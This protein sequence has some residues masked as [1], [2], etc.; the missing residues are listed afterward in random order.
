MDN[1]LMQTKSYINMKFCIANQLVKGVF[2]IIIDSATCAT[3]NNNYLLCLACPD[4]CQN[5]NI[6]SYNYSE[7]VNN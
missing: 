4:K 3:C 1:I 6:N 7:Y 5:F 2:M